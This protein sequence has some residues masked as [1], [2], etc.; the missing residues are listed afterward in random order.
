MDTFTIAVNGVSHTEDGVTPHDPFAAPLKSVAPWNFELL[1]ALMFIV[2]SLSLSENFT[3]MLVTFKFKQLRQ[4]LNYIIVNLS[5]ADFLVSLIGG[6]LSFL[7]NAN[8]YFFLGK[9]ACVV[10]GF[11]V[12][13]FGKKTFHFDISSTKTVF[14]LQI[15][16]ISL[17]VI[18][19]LRAFMPL[20]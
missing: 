15:Y 17:G 12:T 2:T 6:T 5:V 9:S 10:E 4:P 14:S 20:W 7:T 11:A 1:A 16:A 19:V 18:R 13:F 3:V 8:G